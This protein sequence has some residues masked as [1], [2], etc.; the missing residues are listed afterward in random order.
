MGRNLGYHDSD[1]LDRPELNKCPDCECYFATEACPLCGKICPEE[2]RAGHRAAVKPPKM[3]RNSTGRVQFIEW[4]HSW[5][6]I[7]LMF[8]FMPIVGLILFFTSPHPRKTK[9]IV[10]CVAVGIYL[11]FT[12]IGY[13]WISGYF[14]KAPVNDRI[15]RE[16]YEERCED[17]SVEQFYRTNPDEGR[18]VT[19]EVEVL[20][21]RTDWY[22]D[23]YY[24]CQAKG[25][26]RARIY[27]RDCNL[28]KHGQFLRGDVLRV[29]GESAG[30][31]SVSSES[32][33]S[34]SYP[35]LNMAYC[36]RVEDAGVER[37]TLQF[38]HGNPFSMEKR[39]FSDHT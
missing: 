32:G 21:R 37:E 23:V 5:W 31:T 27:L 36:D 9:I 11:L 24:L 6:F 4:Y 17:M 8:Y 14:D 22:G 33:I 3:N 16:K 2:M 7:L 18:Y 10:G 29:Y 26:S 35:C 20:E 38:F 39:K 34:D 28:D 30:L 15:S 13:A 19:M 25:G 1:E 12:A